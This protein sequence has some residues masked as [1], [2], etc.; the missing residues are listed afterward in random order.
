M[1]DNEEVILE[2]ESG[3]TYA[4]LEHLPPQELE[5]L[6][7]EYRSHPLRYKKFL[8]GAA[9]VTVLMDRL[10][11]FKPSHVPGLVFWPGFDEQFRGPIAPAA[12]TPWRLHLDAQ[13][14]LVYS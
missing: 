2:S 1:D 14:I 9:G 11:E 6:V 12:D 13:K 8:N 5:E 3:F 10:L 4:E 7:P